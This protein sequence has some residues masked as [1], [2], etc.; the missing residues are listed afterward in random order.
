MPTCKLTASFI[1]RVPFADSGQ[2]WHW[3]SRTTGLGLQVGTTTKSFVVQCRGKRVTL[4]RADV[5]TV[6]EAREKAIAF[7]QSVRRGEDPRAERAVARSKGE[8]LA[9][10]TLRAAMDETF[11]AKAQFTKA[12][13]LADYRRL[14]EAYLPAWLDKPLA[15]LGRSEVT[16]R[17]AEICEGR[18]LYRT[19]FFGH[20]AALGGLLRGDGCGH[21]LPPGLGRALVAVLFQ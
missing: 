15:T 14:I 20:K 9:A 7:I 1:S 21:P 11:A 3:D 4:G 8:R 10:L 16:K 6:D 13:T 5:L 12:Q 17:F 2:E 19:R 18:N